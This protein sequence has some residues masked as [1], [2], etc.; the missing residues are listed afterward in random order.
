MI[1]Y[2]PASY[3]SVALFVTTIDVVNGFAAALSIE[4]IFT[5]NAGR[6]YLVVWPCMTL[7]DLVS[8]CMTLY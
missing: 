1:H 8:P 6:T 7:Y 4:A 5:A 2:S 3:I